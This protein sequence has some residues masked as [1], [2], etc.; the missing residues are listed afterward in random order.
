MD[1]PKGGEIDEEI[2]VHTRQRAHS[3]DEGGESNTETT[4]IATGGNAANVCEICLKTFTSASA[5]R[6]HTMSKH[7][8]LNVKYQ[9]S[10]CGMSY[11][12][13]WSLS[14]HISRYHRPAS[15]KM[16]R[17]KNTNKRP[18]DA[19]DGSGGTEPTEFVVVKNE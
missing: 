12:T 18:S 1:H 4:V 11:K 2:V 17:K 5:M 6:R 8:A 16:V 13:K 19:G 7:S 3:K 9:C 14:T 15:E 10:I